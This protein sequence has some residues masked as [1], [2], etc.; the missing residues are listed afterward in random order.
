MLTIF[1]EIETSTKTNGNSMSKDS[2]KDEI[3]N[4]KSKMI[5]FKKK[6]GEMERI[7]NCFSQIIHN[8]QDTINEVSKDFNELSGL[9]DST[10][11]SVKA[12][13]EDNSDSENSQNLSP[14]NEAKKNKSKFLHRVFL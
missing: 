5:I 2:F 13:K 9:I 4:A 14:E 8:D 11:L 12:L 3:E 10:I 1:I 7:K 6:F